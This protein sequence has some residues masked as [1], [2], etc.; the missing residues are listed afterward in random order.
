MDT[1]FL[2]A[3]ART[4]MND[5]RRTT[6]PTGFIPS[7]FSSNVFSPNNASVRAMPSDNTAL[8]ATLTAHARIAEAEAANA[9][10]QYLLSKRKAAMAAVRASTQNLQMLQ[11]SM[12]AWQQQPRASYFGVTDHTVP[13]HTLTM[14]QRPSDPLESMRKAEMEAAGAFPDLARGPSPPQE[15]TLPTAPRLDVVKSFSVDTE[16]LKQTKAVTPEP[17]VPSP[18]LSS[19]EAKLLQSSLPVPLAPLVGSSNNARHRIGQSKSPV[20]SSVASTKCNK[21]TKKESKKEKMKDD[22]P[23]RSF[24]AYNIF[25]AVEREKILNVVPDDGIQGEDRDARIQAVVSRLQTHLT[26]EEEEIMEKN[27]ACKILKE[28]CQTVGQCRK[29]R[30]KHR[31]SHGKVGFVDMTYIISRRWKAL[32]PAKVN[33]YKD[34]GRMDLLR[35]QRVMDEYNQRKTLLLLAHDG[36][37]SQAS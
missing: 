9:E 19:Q 2:P 25:F 35:F 20:E 33:W 13:P 21:R 16:E 31:K 8:L 1:R 29:A 7:A 36:V 14:D 15:V 30:R 11:H 24:T 6:S 34:L 5:P 37:D 27:A 17:F 12:A 32:S 10:M 26:P 18:N 3:A 23:K 22:M 4:V 28:Q